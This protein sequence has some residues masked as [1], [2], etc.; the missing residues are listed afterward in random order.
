MLLDSR[1]TLEIA[2]RYLQIVKFFCPDWIPATQNALGNL[3]E[4]IAKNANVQRGCSTT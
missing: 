1:W 4:K 2:F 3:Q